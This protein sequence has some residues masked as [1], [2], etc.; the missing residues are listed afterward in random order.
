MDVSKLSEEE[1]AVYEKYGR[2]PKRNEILKKRNDR[3]RG[4]LTCL[5]QQEVQRVV[6]FN[7]VYY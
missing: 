6:T 1:K 5:L 2:V 7:K 4:T 3:L